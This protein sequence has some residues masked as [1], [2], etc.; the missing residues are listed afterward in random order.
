MAQ[1]DVKPKSRGFWWLW[2]IIAI[3]VIAAAWYFLGGY[4]V[5]QPTP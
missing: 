2:L 1:L 4:G 5:K 3:I